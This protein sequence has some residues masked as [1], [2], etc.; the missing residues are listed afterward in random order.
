MLKKIRDKKGVEIFNT[1]IFYFVA[2]LFASEPV[3][4]KSLIKS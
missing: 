3:F 4:T 2:S 1:Y